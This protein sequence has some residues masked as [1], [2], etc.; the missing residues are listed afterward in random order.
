[1]CH[2]DRRHR[3]PGLGGAPTRTDVADLQK[4]DL[5]RVMLSV[6]VINGIMDTTGIREGNTSER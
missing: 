1:M 4:S 5:D 3:R 2:H 6:G